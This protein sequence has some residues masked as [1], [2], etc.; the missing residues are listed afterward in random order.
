MP[1]SEQQGNS[2]LSFPRSLH[3]YLMSLLLFLHTGIIYLQIQILVPA[4]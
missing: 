2:S 3:G 4:K 1:I